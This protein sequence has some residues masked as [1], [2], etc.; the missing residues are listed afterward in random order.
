MVGAETRGG[1]ALDARER[2]KAQAAGSGV[3]DLTPP[4]LA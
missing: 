1:T 2:W 4:Y 3:I